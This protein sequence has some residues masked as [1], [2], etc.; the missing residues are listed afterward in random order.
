MTDEEAQIVFGEE[1]TQGNEPGWERVELPKDMVNQ[2]AHYN[3]GD[4]EC[5]DAIKAMLG[6]EGFVAYCRGNAVKYQWRAGLKF[7]RREDMRKSVWYT[8]MADGDDPRLDPTPV[9]SLYQKDIPVPDLR[10]TRSY[11]VIINTNTGTVRPLTEKEQRPGAVVNLEPNEK[12][13][14]Q[15]LPPEVVKNYED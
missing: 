2:P 3:N 15:F 5:I 1:E 7:N 9:G 14:M 6:E 10:T 4:I 8:R 12:L 13:T 11:R